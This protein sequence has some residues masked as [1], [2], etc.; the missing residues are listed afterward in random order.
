MHFHDWRRIGW[1]ILTGLCVALPYQTESRVRTG[2]DV[3]REVRRI[4]RQSVCAARD[5]KADVPLT[6]EDLTLRRPGTGIPAAQLEDVVGR[7]L[8]TDIAKGNLIY[9]GDLER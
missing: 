7:I 5:L 6:R 4:S 2:F 9:P 8:A 3:E 1:L